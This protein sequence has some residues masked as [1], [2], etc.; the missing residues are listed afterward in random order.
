MLTFFIVLIFVPVLGHNLSCHALG[1]DISSA[2]VRAYISPDGVAVIRG[3]FYPSNFTHY[4]KSD[5]CWIRQL[6]W[7]FR[8]RYNYGYIHGRVGP[9]KESEMRLDSLGL[10][11]IP[12]ASQL[13]L[14][15]RVCQSVVRTFSDL[16]YFTKPR[17]THQGYYK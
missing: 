2:F 4:N 16:P 17:L 13:R 10:R 9:E 1:K 7:H 15:V 5:V 6:Y 8:L 14:F 11:T 3:F 12:K